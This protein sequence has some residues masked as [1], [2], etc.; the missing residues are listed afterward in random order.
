ME[1]TSAS[2]S[3]RFASRGSNS[4]IWMP[5]TLVE[6]GRKELLVLGSQVSIW[7]GPPSSQTRMQALA[8]APERS[9]PAVLSA[10]SSRRYWVRWAPRN[11]SEPTRMKSRRL[12]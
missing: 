7:L 5:S 6:M 12:Q 11:P 4:E 3:I 9:A 8:F 2:L 1:R 10:A